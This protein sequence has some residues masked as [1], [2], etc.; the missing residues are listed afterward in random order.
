M[1][2][3][4]RVGAARPSGGRR[5]G[6]GRFVERYGSWALIAGA[7]EG[8]GAAY[9]RA[10]AANG[11]NLVLVARRGE[12]LEKLAAEIRGEFGVGTRCVEGDVAAAPFLE[13]LQAQCSTLDL[14]VLVC[15]AAQS[16]IGDFGTRDPDDLQRVVDVNVR[17]P[18]TLVRSFL[19]G[20]IERG[21]GAV[22]LMTSLTGNQGTPRIAAYAASKAFL[23]V[24][25]ESLWYECRDRGVDVMACI[26][27]VVRTPGYKAAAG[28]DAPGALDPEQVVEKALRVL[29]RGPVVTPGVVNKIVSVVL[30]RLLPRRASLAILAASTKSL[31]QLRDT[32]GTA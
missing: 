7:S 8:L 24:L 4:G 2:S 28:K 18:V 9:A 17:A 12:P 16:P 15:N 31:A 26:C 25:A 11:M 1:E 27:G 5:G 29:G 14:G 22:V 10:L 21:R 6:Q 19:P 32:K 3:G 13:T 30:T 20:M 23:R